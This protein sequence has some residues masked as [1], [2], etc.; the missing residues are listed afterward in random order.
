MTEIMH[1][2]CSLQFIGIEVNR[3][4]LETVFSLIL[5]IHYNLKVFSQKM[6]ES[7]L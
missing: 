2:Q 4:N 5:D 3:E 6:S 1:L 7:P